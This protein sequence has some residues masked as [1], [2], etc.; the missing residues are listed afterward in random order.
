MARRRTMIDVPGISP[1]HD[2]YFPTAARIDNTIYSSAIQ[3]YDAEVGAVPDDGL[4]QLRLC[5]GN[6]EQFLLGAGLTPDDVIRVT[7]YLG[8]PALRDPANEPFARLFPD[9]HN[10]PARYTVNATLH[11]NLKIQLDFVAIV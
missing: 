8:D 6:F 2:V 11:A 10:R 4:E 1:S 9:E 7:V 5:F 3:G